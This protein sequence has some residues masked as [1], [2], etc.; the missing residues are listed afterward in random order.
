MNIQ[1][2]KLSTATTDNL[3]TTPFISEYNHV[4]YNASTKK[5][6]ESLSI[7]VTD[8]KEFMDFRCECMK[9]DINSPFKPNKEQT[10]LYAK[11]NLASECKIYDEDKKEAKEDMEKCFYTHSA[12]LMFTV[13]RY[14]MSGK[15]GLSFKC[16]QIQIKPK[17]N[18]FK[19]CLFD[20]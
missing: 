12:R 16:R 15:T 18:K 10:K 11:F 6:K 8:N 17:E 4:F 3:L 9:L 13:H 7:D 5:F 20:N 14:S 19:D 1:M 2:S